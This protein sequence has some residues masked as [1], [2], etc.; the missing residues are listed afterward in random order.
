MTDEPLFPDLEGNQAATQTP[1]ASNGN[2]KGDGKGAVPDLFGEPAPASSTATASE[3]SSVVNAVVKKTGQEQILGP[4]PQTSEGLDVRARQGLNLGN[5]LLKIA[6]VLG[7]LTYVFFYTQINPNFELFGKNAAQRLAV[8]E[9]SFVE[10]QSSINLYNY[11]IAKFAL[12]DFV[13]AGDSYLLK[14]AQYESDYTSINTKVELE[15]ELTQLGDEIH[16]A[17]T[18]VKDKLTH[19][20]YPQSLLVAGA[21]LT[22]LEDTYTTGFKSHISS[23]KQAL[24][25]ATDEESMIEASNLDS[26]LAMLNAEDFRRDIKAL[27]LEADL[28]AAT[29]ESLFTQ[30]TQTSRDEFSAILSIKSDRVNW[31]SILDEIDDLTREVDPLYG[32]GIAS[33]IEYSNFAFNSEDRSITLTGLT[34]TDDTLNF[35]LI[36]DLLDVLEQSPL[37]SEV[38]NR[39]FTK[40]EDARNGFTSTFTIHLKLQEGDDSR[41]AVTTAVITEPETTDTVQT[42]STDLLNVFRISRH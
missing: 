36:S 33:N 10:E 12:D 24:R 41:D 2:G 23:E 39:S 14:L 7:V 20:L 19:P 18:V 13:V 17:L 21:S 32:S 9:T 5:L 1:P 22:D 31:A 27:D 37:F 34:K 4:K 25:G 8:F 16:A 29:I 15:G 3:E 40:T 30:A 35:S 28:D 42:G 26:V 38:S 11:L 6:V